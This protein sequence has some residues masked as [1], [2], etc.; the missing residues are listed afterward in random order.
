[1]PKLN[2]YAEKI[3]DPWRGGLYRG[4]ITGQILSIR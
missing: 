1:L 3:E 2:L 4:S